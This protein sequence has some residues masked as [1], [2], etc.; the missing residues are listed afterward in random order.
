MSAKI[1]LKFLSKPLAEKHNAA[2]LAFGRPPIARG[3]VLDD[4]DRLRAT[5]IERLMCDL[6]VDLGE[7][8]KVFDRESRVFAEEVAGLSA[9]AADGLVQIEEKFIRVTEQ[10]RPF[11]RMVCAGFDSYYRTGV[12]RSTPAV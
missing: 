12:E 7:V 4:D 2:A 6:Q 5:V 8:C 11:V 3:F 10:G 9:L 1:D